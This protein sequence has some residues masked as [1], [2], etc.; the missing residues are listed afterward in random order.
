MD[1]HKGCADLQVV[2]RLEVVSGPTGRRRWPPDVK[3]RI[4][5]ESFEPD[6][7]VCEVARRHGLRP[8]HLFTWRRQARQGRLVM[9]YD[10]GAAF[11]PVLVTSD[12]DDERPTPV[13]SEGRIEIDVGG[14]ILRLPLETPARRIAEI[15]TVLRS[16]T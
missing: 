14:V 9:P 5:A 6:V 1:I 16:A 8:S 15:V 12:R 13:S 2:R 4:V 3:A 7:S 11:A 10:A